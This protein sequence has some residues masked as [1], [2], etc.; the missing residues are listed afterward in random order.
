MR[1]DFDCPS[2]RLLAGSHGAHRVLD[3]RVAVTGVARVVRVGVHAL[4]STVHDATVFQGRLE[5]VCTTCA[6]TPSTGPKGFAF[7]TKNEQKSLGGVARG[8][9]VS[10]FRLPNFHKSPTH[11]FGLLRGQRGANG[12][13]R[14][15][16]VPSE[17]CL[18][19]RPMRTLGNRWRGTL[20]VVARLTDANECGRHSRCSR[21]S[22]SS[23][24][25]PEHRDT[26]DRS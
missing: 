5:G 6:V 24:C 2:L 19:I 17:G 16:V 9:P 8:W 15:P 12:N 10:G 18:R 21:C 1:V 26:I 3:V 22:R 14:V 20:W 4:Q 11:P 23:A 7:H 25:A 13:G